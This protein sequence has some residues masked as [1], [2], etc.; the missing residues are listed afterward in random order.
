MA[1]RVRSQIER[2]E[3]HVSHIGPV[4]AFLS[5]EGR[6]TEG[7]YDGV[8]TPEG[9][10]YLALVSELLELAHIGLRGAAE[11]AHVGR[12]GQ[13]VQGQE[14]RRQL[15]EVVLMRYPLCGHEPTF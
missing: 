1:Q 14:S 7:K 13:R 5:C 11:K 12:V 6:G 8:Q 15:H 9:Q 10:R 4:V 3:I 2:D